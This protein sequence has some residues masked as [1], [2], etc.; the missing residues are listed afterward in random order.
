MRKNKKSLSI[1]GND[2]FICMDCGKDTALDDKDYYM[3]KFEIWDK[4]VGHSGMLCMDCM[5]KRIGHKL[6]KDDILDCPLNNSCNYYTMKI[7]NS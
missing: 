6:T 3:V 4:F 1:T 5:E 7:L 2:N